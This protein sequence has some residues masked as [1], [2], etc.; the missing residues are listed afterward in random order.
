L[1][2]D[3][4]RIATRLPKEE[5]AYVMILQTVV[6]GPLLLGRN[7]ALGRMEVRNGYYAYSGSAGSGLRGRWKHH[8]TLAEELALKWQVDFLRLRCSVVEIWF[9]TDPPPPAFSPGAA[10]SDREC[11]LALGVLAMRGATVP[12]L[13]FGSP[14]RGC[15]AYLAY[16]ERKPSF[17][18]FQ[19]RMQQA[20]CPYRMQRV[21]LG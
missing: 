17:R 1:P 7:G 20:D 11:A 5:G 18:A 15:P 12:V 13:G 2:V 8:L 21:V 6:P 3:W 4:E 19:V 10:R 14:K 16:F 9:T